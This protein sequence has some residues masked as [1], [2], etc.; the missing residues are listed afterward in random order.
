MSELNDACWGVTFIQS[1]VHTEDKNIRKN[2]IVG[3]EFTRGKCLPE[4]RKTQLCIVQG[5]IKTIKEKEYVLIMGETTTLFYLTTMFQ[6][7]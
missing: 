5:K 4:R 2:R 7:N 6:I 1:C 3:S